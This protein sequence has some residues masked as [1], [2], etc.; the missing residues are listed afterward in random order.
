MAFLHVILLTPNFF[1][2]SFSDSIF[3]SD[4]YTSL[5]ILFKIYSSILSNFIIFLVLSLYF[6]YMSYA[7]FFPVF[8]FADITPYTVFLPE[9]APPDHLH[10]ADPQKYHLSTRPYRPFQNK[11]SGSD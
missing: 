7:C 8:L 3:S 10:K 9:R 11:Q 1:A 6:Y 5:F 2:S 4:K